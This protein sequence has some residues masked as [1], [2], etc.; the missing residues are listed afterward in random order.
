[1]AR[2]RVAGALPALVMAGV[3]PWTAAVDNI[4]PCGMAVRLTRPVDLGTRLPVE[5]LNRGR[6]CWHLKVMS[7][8]H[9]TPYGDG[10]WLVGNI[11][12]ARFTDDE[13]RVL[14]PPTGIPTA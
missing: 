8:V 6:N 4:S 5:L 1:V 13:F 12:L 10:E 9:V 11:F 7:V 14:L 3:R 2:H